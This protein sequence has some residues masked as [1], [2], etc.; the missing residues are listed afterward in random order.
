MRQ[1]KKKIITIALAIPFSVSAWAAGNGAMQDNMMGME[2]ADS[3]Q[4]SADQIQFQVLSESVIDT[5]KFMREEEKLA[6][7]VYQ[8]LYAQWFAPAF[9]N[10]SASE[11]KHM[12]SV[13]VFLDAYGIEDPASDAPGVFNNS[14]LQALYDQLT[15]QG[16]T[17]LLEAYKV[18]ALIEEVDIVDLQ[19]AIAN[20]DII[21]LKTMYTQLL[22]GSYN[23]LRAFSRQ[24]VLLDESAVYSA[25]LMDQVDVDTILAGEHSGMQMG[26][27]SSVGGVEDMPSSSCFISS[28]NVDQQTMQ[29]G[30]TV[31]ANQV[32]NVA[33]QVNVDAADIGQTADWVLVASYT[34]GPNESAQFFV[35]NAEQWQNWNGQMDSLPA[36]MNTVLQQQQS[37]PVFEGSLNDM[38]GRY[39]I[40]AGYRLNNN[41]LVYN[42]NPLVFSVNP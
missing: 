19:E 3:C 13:K 33:Y 9:D 35:R 5:L 17:S 7:D 4:L 8:A 12:D 16:S 26:N 25:Q 6:R 38:A 14:D 11:Q 15:E 22:N 41:R 24:I 36:A 2:H 40:Y 30:S 31:N 27:A 42:Q 21:E 29:N 20:T 32:L 37:V 10:I 28:L 23:H 39:S 34:P 18:G 1:F